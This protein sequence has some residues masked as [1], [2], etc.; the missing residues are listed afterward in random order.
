MQESINNSDI[1]IVGSGIFGSVIAERCATELGLK[2][3]VI[4]QRNHIGGNCYTE[5]DAATGINIHRYG[6]HIF[7]TSNERVWNYI[8]QFT[9]FNGYKHQCM[10]KIG[11]KIYSMPIN[12]ATINQRLNKCWTPT[13]AKEFFESYSKAYPSP[14]NFEEQAMALMGNDLYRAFFRE[15]TIKQ[16][17]RDPVDLPA[18]VARRLPVRYNYNTRY[19]NDRW[20]GIPVDGYTPIFQKMLSHPN[21]EVLLETDYFDIKHMIPDDKMTVYSGPIDRFFDYKYGKLNWRTCDFEFKTF[22]VEDHQGVTQI[23]Y[24]TLA[25]PYT[26]SIEFRHFHP[27]RNY[28]KAATVVSFEYSRASTEQDTPFYPVNT[29]E[30]HKKY[31]MYHLDAKNLTN[32]IIGGR[33][34]EYMYYDMHQV[35]GAALTTYEKRIKNGITIKL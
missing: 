34:G 33:L 7:H 5:D 16:W 10:S 25:V 19:Y 21:I 28:T 11:K 27:E 22:P 15:Y 13:Q 3:L 4:E 31:S 2:V 18:S 30:D 6:P 9:E 20:E 1:V 29:E 24:P 35:I 14:Q 17:D 32:T 12:L 23:N 26:R 8:N